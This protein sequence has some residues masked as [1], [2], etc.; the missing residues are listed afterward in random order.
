MESHEKNEQLS[1]RRRSARLAASRFDS[2]RWVFESCVISKYARERDA[3]RWRGGEE[4]GRDPAWLLTTI[5]TY[6]LPRGAH[7]LSP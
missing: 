3:T 2:R 1:E 5:L 6:Q 7:C 4:S